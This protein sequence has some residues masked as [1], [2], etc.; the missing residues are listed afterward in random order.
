M[1]MKINNISN[2]H[3]DLEWALLLMFV[4]H[5]NLK[6]L[7]DKYRRY[8]NNYSWYSIIWYHGNL[9]YPPQSYPGYPPS[10]HILKIWRISAILQLGLMPWHGLKNINQV[11]E[12]TSSWWL[13]QP[14][15]KILYKMDYFPKD[16]GKHKKQWNHH[17]DMFFSPIVGSHEKRFK[18]SLKTIPFLDVKG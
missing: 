10:H 15:W 12:M 18:G 3:P 9:R 7:W 17:L 1:I 13:N 5:F 16:R 11:I 4:L 6:F 14:I 8:S 2:H